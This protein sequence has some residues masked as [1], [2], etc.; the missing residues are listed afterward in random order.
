[1]IKFWQIVKF[2]GAGDVCQDFLKSLRLKAKTVP[3]QRQHNE[4][5]CYFLIR[6][7]YFNT[8]KYCFHQRVINHGHKKR[9]QI[10]GR[11][12]KN[13][14][15]TKS[16]CCAKHLQQ[17]ELLL[18]IIFLL[19]APPEMNFDFPCMATFQ[20][21]GLALQVIKKRHKQDKAMSILVEFELGC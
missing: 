18:P 8:C 19:K 11:E 6:F 20:T 14:D 16:I 21:S 1:M 5:A 9:A 17:R 10:N 13:Y 7:S 12:I 2:R 15:S 3:Q 4:L